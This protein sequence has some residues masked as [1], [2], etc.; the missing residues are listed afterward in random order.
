LNNGP[1]PLT[2]VGW[3]RPPDGI[4][5]DVSAY[6]GCAKWQIIATLYLAALTLRGTRYFEGTAIVE[7]PKKI[8]P[9]DVTN[10]YEA[11][12]AA[13]GAALASSS[14]PWGRQLFFVGVASTILAAFLSVLDVVPKLQIAVNFAT[15]AF[16]AFGALC[17][18]ISFVLRIKRRRGE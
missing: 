13:T 6:V 5:A 4:V 2:C 11:P 12:R 3:E 8:P 1:I 10:P 17:L 15:A 7:R 9:T 14:L 16:A 18:S